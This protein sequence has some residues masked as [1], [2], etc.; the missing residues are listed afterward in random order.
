MVK[1]DAGLG[2][3]VVMLAVLFFLACGIAAMAHEPYT[4]KTDPIYRRDGTLWTQAQSS[5]KPFHPQYQGCC[6]GS[7]CAPI[8]GHVAA[9][10]LT[11]ME[12]GGWHVT[13]TLEESRLINAFSMYPI[14]AP[15]PAARVQQSFDGQFHICIW[16]Q[17]RQPGQNGGIICF[18]APPDA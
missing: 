1:T 11:R 10:A 15:V 14:N 2:W 13:L 3:L 5:V 17:L 9:H 18:W 6:S 12:D 8:P 4:G 16:E 7:D